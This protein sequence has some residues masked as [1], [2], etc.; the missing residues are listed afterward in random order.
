MTFRSQHSDF[1]LEKPF[2]KKKKKDILV[3]IIYS[4]KTNI[5]DGLNFLENFRDIN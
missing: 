2:K 1:L 4:F 5:M 3:P